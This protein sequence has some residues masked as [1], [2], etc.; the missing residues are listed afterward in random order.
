MDLH[1][2]SPLDRVAVIPKNPTSRKGA[3]SGAPSAWLG[4]LFEG[5]YGGGFVVF[6]VEDGVEL[7]DLEQV[8]HLLGEVEAV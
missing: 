2:R 5:F 8:V 6:H 7:G 3:R 4:S 1:S